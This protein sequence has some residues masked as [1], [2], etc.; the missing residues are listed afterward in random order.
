MKW[1]T[2]WFYPTLRQMKISNLS[3]IESRGISKNPIPSFPILSYPT[4][5]YPFVSYPTLPYPT[6][7]YPIIFFPIL[8]YPIQSYPIIPTFWSEQQNCR[9]SSQTR[10]WDTNHMPCFMFSKHQTSK[11]EMQKFFLV[12]GKY[13][14]VYFDSNL[15]SKY[16]SE[17]L[18]FWHMSNL[19][20]I[21]I[22]SN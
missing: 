2:V 11:L 4:L 21:R 17:L 15:V 10:S 18:F 8:P 20:F 6:L 3:S 7:S 12:K 14:H 1:W 16:C 9:L 22:N 19:K 13:L 5:S